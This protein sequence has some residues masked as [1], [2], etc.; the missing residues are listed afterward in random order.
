MSTEEKNQFDTMAKEMAAIK[1]WL[2]IFIFLGTLIG[3]A[4]TSTSWFDNNIARKADTDGIRKEVHELKGD[5]EDLKSSLTGFKTITTYSQAKTN[6]RI[7]SIRDVV[8]VIKRRLF[9]G[10]VTESFPNG[11]NHNPTLNY[12][13]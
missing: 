7:D 4:I 8:K 5:V 9:T 2:P 3:L 13:N 1:R 10:F 12:R 11:R 6:I